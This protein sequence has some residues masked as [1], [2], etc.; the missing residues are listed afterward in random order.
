[1]TAQHKKLT[2]SVL[3]IGGSTFEAQMTDIQIVNDTDDPEQFYTYD[4]S[5]FYEAADPSFSL[6]LT[7]FAD[8]TSGGFS[9]FLWTHDG[10]TMDFTLDHHNGVTGWH[11]QW[12]GEVFVKAPS[13]GGEVR[14]TETSEVTLG[15]VGAPTY[16]RIS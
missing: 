3:D 5:S 4:N 10:E 11:V 2:T 15:I 1:M 7:G 8:W 6:Q 16:T 14:A 9:D 13:A 12:S